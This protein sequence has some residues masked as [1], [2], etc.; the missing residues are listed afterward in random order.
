MHDTSQQRGQCTRFSKRSSGKIVLEKK[1][2]VRTQKLRYRITETVR[3]RGTVKLRAPRCRDEV[4]SAECSRVNVD[5]PHLG[6]QW[7]FGLGV[8]GSESLASSS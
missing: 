2:I 6:L 3:R 1:V 5:R 4:S 8:R 7:Y